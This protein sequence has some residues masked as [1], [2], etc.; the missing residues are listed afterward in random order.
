MNILELCEPLFLYVCRLNRSARKG[1][2]MEFGEARGQ[3][4]GILADMRSRAASV[5]GLAAEFEKIH[6]ALLFFVDFMM[7]ESEL[8]FAA[9][10][11]QKRL[12]FELNEMAGNDKFF[13]L[14]E[15]TLLDSSDAAAERLAVFYTC[16]GLGFTGD[17]YTDQPEY[18]NSKMMECASR[19]RKVMDKGEMSRVCPEAYEHTDPRD[20]VVD[21]GTKLLGIGLAL[22]GLLVVLFI[23]SWVLYERQGGELR[24]SLDNISHP[25]SSTQVTDR[26]EEKAE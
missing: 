13:D 10:W 18:I 19:M 7:A 16:M 23:A 17:W 2:T 3:I 21:P 1:G 6:L 22:V 12:A 11:H 8:P 15:E 5:P 25:A 9:E 4:Q 20:L 26:E 14:L 24:R